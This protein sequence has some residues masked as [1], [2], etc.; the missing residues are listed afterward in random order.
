MLVRFTH[1]VAV[2][3]S[4]PEMTHCPPNTLRFVFSP[5]TA[6]CASVKKEGNPGIFG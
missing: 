4:L 2:L 5:S 1:Q 3:F 6:L